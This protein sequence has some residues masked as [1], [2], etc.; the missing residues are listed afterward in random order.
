MLAGWFQ[1]V[2]AGVNQAPKKKDGFRAKVS[3]RIGQLL[4]QDLAGILKSFEGNENPE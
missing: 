1:E 3:D 2:F 4:P